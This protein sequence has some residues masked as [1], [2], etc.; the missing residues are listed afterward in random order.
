MHWID[1]NDAKLKHM[2]L[3]IF[4]PEC[5]EGV[6]KRLAREIFD[7]LFLL[8]PNSIVK[9]KG[10]SSDNGADA[11]TAA[12]RLIFLINQHLGFESVPTSHHIRCLDHSV[13]LGVK[14]ALD[15]IRAPFENLREGIVS[16]RSS[17]VKRM[18]YRQEARLRMCPRTEP[19]VPDCKTRWNSQHQFCLESLAHRQ[20][21]HATFSEFDDLIA[22]N[23]SPSEW[24]RI[25]TIKDFLAIPRL[26]MEEASRDSSVTLSSVKS[27]VDVL[28]NH[29]NSTLTAA[30]ESESDFL[31]IA[32]NAMKIKLQSYVPKLVTTPAILAEYLDPR[33][34]KPHDTSEML[35]LKSLVRE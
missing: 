2:L 24:K 32:A 9:L 34:P 21:I 8:N 30:L 31:S 1:L 29:C 20:I 25:E 26:V 13:Q 19:P 22:L 14:E 35:Q 17:K 11:V 12:N 28:L 16:I 6:G 27:Q 7:F 4:D 33:F 23:P 5:G 3:F 10:I 15:F 18:R